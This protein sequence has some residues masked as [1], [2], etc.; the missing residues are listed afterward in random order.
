MSCTHMVS[1]LWELNNDMYDFMSFSN[2]VTICETFIN[3]F[4]DHL[5]ISYKLIIGDKFEITNE[6]INA[7]KLSYQHIARN[8]HFTE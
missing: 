2:H 4:S 1:S 6:T 7:N 8:K 5:K 3:Y